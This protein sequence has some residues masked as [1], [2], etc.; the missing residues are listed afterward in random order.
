MTIVMFAG[1]AVAAILLLIM[2]VLDVKAAAAGWLIGFFFWSAIPLGS[3]LLLMIHRLTGGRWGVALHAP[4]SSV[5]AL[6][7]VMAVLLVP[8]LLA[9]PLLYPWAHAEGSVIPSVAHIY[10]NVPS[11]VARSVIAFLGWSVLAIAVP[12]I[13]GPRG[14]LLSA[15]GLVF[16]CVLISLV[17]VDWILSIEHPFFSE[18]FGASVAVTQ[19]IAALSWVVVLGLPD[20]E[21]VEGDIGG[22][23]LAMVLAI[24]YFDYMALLIIWYSD[25]PHKEFWFVEREA[26][27]WWV[28]ALIAFIFGSAVPIVALLLGCVRNHRKPLRAIGAIVL[29]GLAFYDAYLIAPPFGPGTLVAAALALIAI[30]GL[31]AGLMLSDLLAFVVARRRPADVH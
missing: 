17:P 11:F 29:V 5:A 15:I 9:I 23:L 26:A 12:R 14:V 28:L 24:T 19:L 31:L 25:L 18:S 30:G 13:F 16:Y 7:P 3:L 4:L 2:A 10:L 20:D 22:L 6:T 27:P 21:T 1:A 8:V